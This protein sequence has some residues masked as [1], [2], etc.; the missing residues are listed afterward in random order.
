MT[1]HEMSRED[2]RRR[3][4]IARSE[5]RGILHGLA[6]VPPGPLPGAILRAS[7]ALDEALSA[8]YHQPFALPDPNP[9]EGAK[10]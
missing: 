5:M 3:L 1:R 2:V 6:R 9:G 8:T 10:A 4:A 7:A